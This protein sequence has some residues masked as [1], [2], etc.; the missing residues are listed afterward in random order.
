LHSFKAHNLGVKS[1][2]LGCVTPFILHCRD[3]YVKQNE[4]LN[5]FRYNVDLIKKII[6]TSNGLADQVRKYSDPGK[7]HVVPN[8]VDLEKC[9]HQRPES[10]RQKMMIS[11]S[12]IVIGWYGLF[13]KAEP[14]QTWID[15]AKSIISKNIG[16]IKY[17]F[18]LGGSGPALEAVQRIVDNEGLNSQILL[19]GEVMSVEEV[20]SS[21]N[22]FLNTTHRSVSDAYI[23]RAM[24]CRIPI[25]SSDYKGLQE[26]LEHDRT[27]LV[28]PIGDTINGVRQIKRIQQNEKLRSTQI[29]DAYQEVSKFTRTRASE[30]IYN[31]YQ[32]ALQVAEVNTDKN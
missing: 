20:I 19:P 17:R 3:E 12:S 28:F 31:L 7:I 9:A 21:F 16:G 5:K 26:T 23:K 14:F 27:A 2:L 10:F 4:R 32:K 6:C 15:I 24:A 29:R 13:D 30:K 25:V 8:G 1:Y 22:L 18:V 11:D